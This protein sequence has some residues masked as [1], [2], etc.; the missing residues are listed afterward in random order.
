L[1]KILATQEVSRDFS[2]HNK[3]RKKKEEQGGGGRGGG[4][5]GR[6]GEEGEQEEPL[7]YHQGA[8]MGTKGMKLYN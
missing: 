8:N 4:E 6:G 2:L 1:T 5:K 3:T 7:K